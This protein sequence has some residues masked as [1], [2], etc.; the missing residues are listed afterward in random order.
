MSPENVVASFLPFTTKG[1]L[2]GTNGHDPRDTQRVAHT[3]P[4][5]KTNKVVVITDSKQAFQVKHW[6]K[7][8]SEDILG[9][10]L[11]DT[12]L[13]SSIKCIPGIG[14]FSSIFGENLTITSKRHLWSPKTE[15]PRSLKLLGT[16]THTLSLFLNTR[17]RGLTSPC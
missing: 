3:V 16:H 12:Q 2:L 13:S 7:S 4:F 9:N 8:H 11:G 6:L 5:P 17:S 15:P 1:D 10:A 14:D